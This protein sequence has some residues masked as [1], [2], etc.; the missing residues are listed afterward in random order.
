MGKDD[1]LTKN[2]TARK[3]KVLVFG[4]DGGTF[5]IVGNTASTYSTFLDTSVTNGITYYYIVT[6][7][8]NGVESEASNEVSATPTERRRRR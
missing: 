2:A 5:D 8:L 3:K 4:I 1:V 6:S 7:M